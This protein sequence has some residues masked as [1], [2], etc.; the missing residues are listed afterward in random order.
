MNLNNLCMG[1]MNEKSVQGGR[2]PYCGF[3]DSVQNNPRNMLPL[4]TILKGAYVA[5]KA[6]GD[7]GF[8]IT[9]IGMD[10]N[11]QK[12]VAI[13]EYFPY[14]MA[15][16][17]KDGIRVLPDV[18]AED[19]Y[20][21]EKDRFVEEARIL[22]QIDERPGV[23]KVRSYFQEN[24]TAYIVMEFLEGISLDKYVK[25]KGGR[26]EA[27]ELLML[28]RP[29][30]SALAGIHDKGVVHKDISPDNIMVDKAG[31]ARLID[32]GAAYDIHSGVSNL[33]VYKETY[34]PP[35]QRASD[36]EITMAADIY[37]LCTTIYHMMTGIKPDNSIR[38]S[39]NDTLLRPSELGINIS[40]I[41]EEALICGMEPKVSDRISNAAD[42]YYFLYTYGQTPGASGAD[43]RRKIRQSSSK[44]IMDRIAEEKRQDKIKRNIVLVTAVAVVL[45]VALLI[46][47]A[48]I[49]AGHHKTPVV[50]IDSTQTGDTAYKS[51]DPTGKTL[52][53]AIEISGWRDALYENIAVYRDE[54]L[55]KA[56][57]A[58]VSD[59]V[60][61]DIEDTN[62]WNEHINHTADKVFT[63]YGL[64]DIGWLVLPYHEDT[65]IAAIRADAD[66]RIS[67]M[68]KGIKNAL[69]LN[70]ASRVGI[71]VGIHGD[72]TVFT[73]I[74]YGE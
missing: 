16:R 8:G 59:F 52:D 61:T 42:L 73:V 37:A 70:T 32:F 7:G 20:Y 68:N 56:A 5:G 69:D 4:W 66:K 47:R 3:D 41:A 49:Y 28:M 39:E 11:L 14:E 12:K 34:S 17:D 65:D 58:M 38:R 26:M 63:D 27:D 44:V 6:L 60:V 43:M 23:V 36:G 51:D 46:L 2:C 30:V 21:H 9:Y 18:D 31:H 15:H 53:K 10:L 50:S 24:N 48:V 40:P 55:E 25:D 71:A 57:N 13:K 54:T 64:K 33:R 19:F 35:E 29:V 1:C 45:A 62:G 72:G 74:L 67:E 22:A